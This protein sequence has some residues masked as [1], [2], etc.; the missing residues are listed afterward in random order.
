MSCM[1]VGLRFWIVHWEVIGSVY[2]EVRGY[3]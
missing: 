1:S 3:W 2:V